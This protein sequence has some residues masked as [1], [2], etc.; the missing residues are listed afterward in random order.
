MNAF[1]AMDNK[2]ALN[3]L[4]RPGKGVG[5]RYF[6]TVQ[7]ADLVG[8]QDQP[9]EELAGLFLSCAHNIYRNRKTKTT[10]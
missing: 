3:L 2:M 6:D 10:G 5:G 1:M 9:D 7:I 4:L 8:P